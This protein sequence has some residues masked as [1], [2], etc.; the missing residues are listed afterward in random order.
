MLL[1]H[2]V[3]LT[4]FRPN[5]PEIDIIKQP[6]GWATHPDGHVKVAAGLDELER[7]RGHLALCVAAPLAVQPVL[8]I[9]LVLYSD[10]I[11]GMLA[12]GVQMHRRPSI[13]RALHVKA[14]ATAAPAAAVCSGAL[15]GSK[16]GWRRMRRDAQAGDADGGRGREQGQPWHQG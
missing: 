16:E 7:Q 15:A 8:L 1:M 9:I 14:A 10:P 12:V 13:T 4:T 2:K 3:P 11:L 5:A 6:E